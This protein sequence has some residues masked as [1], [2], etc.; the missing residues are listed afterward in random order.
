MDAPHDLLQLC[1]D[2]FARPAQAQRVLRL[3]EARYCDATRIRGLAGREEH[4][5]LLEELRG[6]ERC[7]HIGPLA[8]GH[9]AVLDHFP[10]VVLVDL[11]L[12]R[13]G[14][15]NVRPYPPGPLALMV[16]ALV[17]LRIFRYAAAPHVLQIHQ[18]GELLRID[19]ISVVDKAVRVGHRDDLRAELCR[20]FHGVLGHV[21]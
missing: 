12:R 18:V 6:R 3:L 1:V 2:L 17:L 19:T 4:L 21:A 20:F 7:R 14:K 11:I 9:D 13:A 16:L 10:G 5:V 15:G 8:N